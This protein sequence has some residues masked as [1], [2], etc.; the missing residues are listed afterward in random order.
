MKFVALVVFSLTFTSLHANYSYTPPYNG[1][2][3]FHNLHSNPSYLNSLLSS[4][5][6]TVDAACDE[7]EGVGFP[8]LS[9]KKAIQDIDT[10]LDST[11]PN[12]HA[13]VIF[14]KE[15]ASTTTA[16]TIVK[17]VVMLRSFYSTTYVGVSGTYS[18]IGF[19][20]FAILNYLFDTNLENIRTVM[21]E[22][23]VNA[24]SVF[25]CGDV[26]SIYSQANPVLPNPDQEPY[27][28]GNQILNS[29]ADGN[30]NNANL[31]ADIINLLNSAN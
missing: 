30:P 12:S 2:D 7:I 27:Q 20:T 4:V 22:P 3:Q 5:T 29:Q 25:G 6:T 24:S 9:L 18:Q 8:I 13:K 19:P 31:I 15:S 16:Q 28:Q 10:E 23:N 11:N 14:F 17:L 26:K 21:E 1:G